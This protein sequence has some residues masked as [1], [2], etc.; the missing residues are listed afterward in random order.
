MLPSAHSIRQVDVAAVDAAVDAVVDAA[1]ATAAE[2]IKQV[3]M[4]MWLLHRLHK[5]H[6][7]LAIC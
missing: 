3:H 2:V 7:A 1:V 5:T 6:S 4:L